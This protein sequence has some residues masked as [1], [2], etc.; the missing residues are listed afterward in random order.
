MILIYRPL[1]IL[2]LLASAT[3]NF[4]ATD[5]V[6]AV[7]EKNFTVTSGSSDKLLDSKVLL[8]S[9]AVSGL[10][11]ISGHRVRVLNTF[12]NSK[13]ISGIVVQLD[14]LKILTLLE[15]TQHL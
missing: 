8:K 1:L 11:T 5:K 2:A 4:A 15:S 9:D 12:V 7:T 14:D 13:G 3:T 6:S 10:F